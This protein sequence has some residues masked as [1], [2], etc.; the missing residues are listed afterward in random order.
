MSQFVSRPDTGGVQGKI[1]PVHVNVFP[2]KGTVRGEVFLYDV[3]IK[4]QSQLATE[5]KKEVETG[6]EKIA[7]ESERKGQRKNPFGARM[8]QSVMSKLAKEHAAELK[9]I[10]FAYDGRALMYTTKKLP[11]ETRDFEIVRPNPAGDKDLT[12]QV[13]ITFARNINMAAINDFITGKDASVVGPEDAIMALDIFA[14]NN[15]PSQFHPRR[16]AFHS[17]RNSVDLG[18]GVEAWGGFNFSVRAVQ[19]GLCLNINVQFGAFFKAQH[20]LDFAKELWRVTSL[21]HFS[22]TDAQRRALQSGLRTVLVEMKHQGNYTRRIRI[23]EVSQRNALETHFR[24]DGEEMPVDEYFKFRYNYQLKYPHLPLLIVG[25][26]TRKDKPSMPME[27]CSIVEGQYYIKSLRDR[28]TASMIKVANMKPRERSKQIVGYFDEAHFADNTFFEDLGLKQDDQML[29]LKARNLNSPRLHYGKS[30]VSP[31][32]GAWNLRGVRGVGFAAKIDKWACLVVGSY[33]D[34]SQREAEAFVSQLVTKAGDNGIVF[35]D[36]R[37]PIE[38]CTSNPSHIEETVHRIAQKLSGFDFLVCMV[39]GSSDTYAAIKR[40][41]DV[42]MGFVSQCMLH[43][44]AKRVNQQYLGNL[45]LKINSK[46]GGRNQGLI[47]SFPF[48]DRP[49]MIIGADVTHPVMGG[50]SS[51]VPAI[52]AMVCSTD[53]YLSRYTAVSSIQPA[54]SEEI[55]STK[56]LTLELLRRFGRLVGKSPE[57]I[58]YFRDGVSE[59]QFKYVFEREYKALK[60]ACSEFTQKSIPVT[61]VVC[62]KRHHLRMFS[63]QEVDRSG[64]VLPG[65]VIDRDIG[66]PN[67]FDF[68]L[69]SHSG[70]QGTSRPTKYTVLA[71]ENGFTSDTLQEF[72]YKICFTNARCTRSMSL[73]PPV[74]YAHLVAYRSRIL[75]RVDLWSSET[76]SI[77]SAEKEEETEMLPP[78]NNRILQHN[79]MY[80]M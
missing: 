50:K 33:R 44:F 73:P 14:I 54:A 7:Q 26:P 64:N 31:Q 21:D 27:V 70:I 76:A 71:D 74:F 16:Q 19:K 62:Q 66:S 15:V 32:Q 57:K 52:V 68:Y 80:F 39:D 20:V 59:G 38:Y 40:L 78:I 47:D 43:K 53:R 25:A 13:K 11:F 10:R 65:T 9:D 3:Q 75:A 72:V 22:P 36:R 1:I 24:V 69:L 8:N 18:V 30:E 79:Y 61:F 37:P 41:S 48:M 55:L 51:K 45:L 46:F 63:D 23:Q 67:L 34:V 77:I 12:C 6:Q 5:E 56:S 2:I 60:Q 35:E 4:E 28:Q 58:M 49:V 29:L 42:E 17:Q